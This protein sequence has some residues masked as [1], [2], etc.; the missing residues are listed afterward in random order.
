MMLAPPGVVKLTNIWLDF[1]QEAR[2]AS[3]LHPPQ[4]E[5]QWIASGTYRDCSWGR[6][7]S[8]QNGNRPAIQSDSTR[9]PA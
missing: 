6:R 8:N 5:Q 4:W 7:F 9:F 2:N 3:H 1:S